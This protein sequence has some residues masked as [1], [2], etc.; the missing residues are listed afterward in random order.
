MKPFDTET[1]T[2]IFYAFRYCLGRQTYA[3]GRCAEYLKTNWSRLAES[4][5]EGIK[6]EILYAFDKGRYG[7]ELDREQWASVL[8]CE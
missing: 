1:D 4:T 2:M 7:S 5:R 6:K 3:V 8:E